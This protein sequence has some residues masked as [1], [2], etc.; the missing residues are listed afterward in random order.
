MTPIRN[1][2]SNGASEHAERAARVKKIVVYLKKTYPKPESELAHTTPF[3][4]L[5]AVIMSAQCTDKAVNK[6]TT[7]LFKKYKTPKDFGRAIARF[8]RKEDKSID[9]IVATENIEAVK[10]PIAVPHVDFTEK[11][12]IIYDRLN[13]REYIEIINT[14]TEILG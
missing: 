2:I 7:T 11:D 12:V 1:L 4:F 6:L 14:M 3:Q 9:S 13:A 10:F 5:A 8:F